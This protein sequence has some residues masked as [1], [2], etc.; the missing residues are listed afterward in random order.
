[1][2]SSRSPC[3]SAAVRDP[4]LVEVLVGLATLALILGRIIV[5]CVQSGHRAEGVGY[6]LCVQPFEQ[7]KSVDATTSPT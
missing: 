4:T 7:P 6:H 5:A 2:C 3:C 1:M